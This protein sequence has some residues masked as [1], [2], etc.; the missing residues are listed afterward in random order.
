MKTI[1]AILLMV[2]CSLSVPAQ[3]IE[4][5]EEALFGSDDTARLSDAGGEGAS[6]AVS[7]EEEFFSTELVADV[8]ETEEDLSTLLLTT[9]GVEIGGRFRFDAVSEWNYDGLEGPFGA[10]LTDDPLTLDLGAE[11]FLDARPSETFRVFAK[12]DLS[13]P[14]EALSGAQPVEAGVKELFADFQLSDVLFF[15]AGKQTTNW[16]VGYYFSPADLLNITE[17]DPEDPEAEREGPVAVKIQA[18][19]GAHNL[20]L[21][22]IVEDAGSAWQT[23]VAPKVEFVIGSV[24]L[25]VGA[26]YRA[27]DPPAAMATLTTS[28]SDFDLFAEGLLA[29][30]SDRVFVVADPAAAPFYVS[31]RT[32]ADQLFPAATAGLS[33]R[34]SDDLD[35]FNISL[36]AQYLYNGDGYADPGF[37]KS[38]AAGIAALTAA[39]E[40]GPKDLQ[41]PGRHYGA[42]GAGWHGLLGSDFDL[43]LFWIGNLADGSGMIAPSINWEISDDLDLS[44]K[45]GFQYGEAGEEY[46][47]LGEAM[48][49]SLSINFG[50]GVF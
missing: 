4:T 13:L 16:G 6:A 42:A 27:G 47:P 10:A 39:G 40:L 22:T 18:P 28:F 50:G 49:L 9:D 29:Y 11:I 5:N 20:Y 17:I 24:E 44:V 12:A 15:R 7:A 35:R 38:N 45:T 3:E 32:Y 26:F 25:G 31:T 48:S 30:G 14:H 36:S 41:Q 2:L 34:R 43:N 1:G 37:L 33:Y 21:Y 19:L 23:A 8:Q 46:T